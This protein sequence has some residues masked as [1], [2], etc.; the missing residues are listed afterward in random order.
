MYKIMNETENNRRTTTVVPFSGRNG[1]IFSFADRSHILQGKKH[2]SV[3]FNKYE[4]M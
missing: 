2:F 4:N 1:E 3:N